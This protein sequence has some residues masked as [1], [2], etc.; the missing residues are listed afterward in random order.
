[1]AQFPPLSLDVFPERLRWVRYEAI[2]LPEDPLEVADHLV[3]VVYEAPIA[4]HAPRQRLL[5]PLP[6]P[7]PLD[8]S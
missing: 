1:M 7:P 2:V 6:L 3:S 5:A 8:P 4:P